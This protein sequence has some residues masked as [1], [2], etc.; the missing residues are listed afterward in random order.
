MA[1][2]SVPG[3]TILIG[4]SGTGK[5]TV[6]RALADRL[7]WDLRDTDDMIVARFGRSIAAVFRDE[8]EAAFR[9]AEKDAVRAA[10]G[11]SR[12]VISV[13]GGAVVD[14][15][16][17]SV[18]AAGNVVVRLDANPETIL[19][20]LRRGVNAEERPMIAGAD[21]LARIKAL[22]A[23]RAEAYAAADIVVSTDDRSIPAIVNDIVE[24]VRQKL[25]VQVSIE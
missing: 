25:V 9:A 16:N 23:N 11:G 10:C 12:R 8:G 15:A 22:L 2:R 18:L 1:C 24:Q 4:F 5:S 17:R 6:G 21:P 19:S 3:N 13:G 20:R 14:Q 7:G